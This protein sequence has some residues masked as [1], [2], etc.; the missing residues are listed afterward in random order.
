MYGLIFYINK[1]LF[2][3]FFIQTSLA[4]IKALLKLHTQLYYIVLEKISKIRFYI[5]RHIK[6]ISHRVLFFTLLTSLTNYFL[7][8]L[9]VPLIIMIIKCCNLLLS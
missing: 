7:Y 6:C 5:R 1:S 8:E 3:L 9:T 2:Y 4:L